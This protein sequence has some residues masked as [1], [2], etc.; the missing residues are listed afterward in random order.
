MLSIMV[1]STSIYE[2]HAGL[3]GHIRA[4][5]YVLSFPQFLRSN[6][7]EDR[8]PEKKRWHFNFLIMFV[9]PICLKREK[10]TCDSQ[11]LCTSNSR[12]D[13]FCT[14]KLE[15]FH[16]RAT[17]E[18]RDPK[19]SNVHNHTNEPSKCSL[20]PYYWS[21]PWSKSKSKAWSS[22]IIGKL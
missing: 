10:S 4:L 5:K 7:M 21:L 1:L 11:A 22:K 16:E 12:T 15:I 17:N 18:H 3:Y 9:S 13:I 14:G 8:L 6:L 2:H 20:H 19:C